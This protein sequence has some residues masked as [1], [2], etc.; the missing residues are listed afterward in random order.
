MIVNIVKEYAN[1]YENLKR[2]N[3]SKLIN[4]VSDDIE[5]EDPFN[6]VKGR[7]NFKIL[8]EKMFD[9]LDKPKFIVL[10]IFYKKKKS[11]IKWRFK[12]NYRNNKHIFEGISEVFIQNGK[13][14]RHVDYWDTGVN[15][16]CKLPFI[17]KIF[18]LIHKKTN[19][20]S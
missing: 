10:E 11:I 17:G 12:F 20:V 8:F 16:Y 7:K 15:L 2:N 6:K 3:I 5:F 9:M 1:A 13:I 19:E 18:R 4:Y 14:S